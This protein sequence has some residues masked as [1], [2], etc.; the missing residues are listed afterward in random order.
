[1]SGLG[2]PLPHVTSNA[3]SYRLLSG[4]REKTVS[5]FFGLEVLQAFATLK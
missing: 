5:I 2:T 3:L 4:F 1:M